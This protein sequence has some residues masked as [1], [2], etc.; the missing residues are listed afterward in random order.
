MKAAFIDVRGRTKRCSSLP[1]SKPIEAY[2]VARKRSTIC[3]S[4]GSTAS[5]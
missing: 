4:I 1:Y 5:V 3:G 2:S